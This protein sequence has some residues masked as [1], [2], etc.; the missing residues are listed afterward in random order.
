MIDINSPPS[1]SDEIKPEEPVQG[2]TYARQ[3][4]HP[5]CIP[6]KLLTAD[7]PVHTSRGKTVLAQ[8]PLAWPSV[9]EVC[10]SF[11]LL[12]GC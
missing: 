4:Q 12:D 5:P 3:A 8:V 9:V 1:S 6:A 10:T 2:V 11:W 7:V